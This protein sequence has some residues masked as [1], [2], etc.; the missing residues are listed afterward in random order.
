M[1]ETITLRAFG[2]EDLPGVLAL[3]HAAVHAIDRKIYS[4]AQ[5]EAWAPAEPDRERWKKKLAMETVIVA[6]IAET[7]AGVCSWTHDGWLDLLYVHPDF[8]RRGVATALYAEAEWAL[9][10]VGL[11][12]IGTEASLVAQPF[13]RRQGLRLV[14]EQ[15]VSVRGVAMPNAVMEK[16]L[17]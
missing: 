6:E 16:L 8:Q 9:R 1:Q 14:K 13:F 17:R 5:I 3:F 15:T 7:M 4:Q 11:G 10:E 12:K 2:D